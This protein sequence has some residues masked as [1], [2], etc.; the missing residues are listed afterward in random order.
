MKLRILYLLKKEPSK[1]LEKII[2]IQSKKNEINIVKLDEINDFK[3]FVKNLFNFD[4]V[5]CW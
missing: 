1:T 3:E 4:R 5:I 2:Q